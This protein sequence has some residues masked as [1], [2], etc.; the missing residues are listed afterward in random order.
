[1]FQFLWKHV[2]CGGMGKVVVKSL[3]FFYIFYRMLSN[4]YGAVCEFSY[5]LKVVLS[6]KYKLLQMLPCMK[7][8]SYF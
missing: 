3:E 6:E 4:V 7:I 2:P 1:M 5:K 8:T